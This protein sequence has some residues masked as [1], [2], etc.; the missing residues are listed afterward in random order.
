MLFVG[1]RLFGWDRDIDRHRRAREII[2]LLI[3][4][5]HRRDDHRSA[6]GLLQLAPPQIRSAYPFCAIVSSH[7][8]LRHY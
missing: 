4:I 5:R 1:V 3:E 6:G 2:N 8:G 7:R